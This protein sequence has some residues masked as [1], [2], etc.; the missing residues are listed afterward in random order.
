VITGIEG[1]PLENSGAEVWLSSRAPRIDETQILDI[2]QQT[3]LFLN[4]GLS[5]NSDGKLTI[6]IADG[7]GTFEFFGSLVP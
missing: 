4:M 5:V 7:G 1:T 6:Q 2:D 3:Q